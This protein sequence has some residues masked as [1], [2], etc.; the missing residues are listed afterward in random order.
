ME[1]RREIFCI[2]FG[3]TEDSRG[4]SNTNFTCIQDFTAFIK[5]YG[6]KAQWESD[7]IS[8]FNRELWKAA[9]ALWGYPVWSQERLREDFT[10]S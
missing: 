7:G 10:P 5:F 6:N 1:R 8:D 9:V 2:T 3:G 4:N